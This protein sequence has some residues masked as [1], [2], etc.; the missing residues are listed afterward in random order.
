MFHLQFSSALCCVYRYFCVL[1]LA[2]YRIYNFVFFSLLLFLIS[3]FYP[4]R[5]E[6]LPTSLL[7]C[8]HIH[9][10]SKYGAEL[11]RNHFEINHLRSIL[12]CLFVSSLGT[13]RRRS[14]A[15]FL[16]Q[17]SEKHIYIHMLLRWEH[18]PSRFITTRCD[19]CGFPIRFGD[20]FFPD[21]P[22]P[23]TL[24]KNAVATLR[25]HQKTRC[26]TTHDCGE[27]HL[28]EHC[29]PY[30]LYTTKN[31]IINWIREQNKKVKK[32]RNI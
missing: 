30:T 11:R 20:W 26:R 29:L 5:F 13:R 27:F 7:N 9:I 17:M 6:T 24:N 8:T 14:A 32:R 1:L 4:E 25:K 23:G 18:F 16:N 28:P 12:L 3:Y 19:G 15:Q 22:G 10:P 2:F 31:N 21:S